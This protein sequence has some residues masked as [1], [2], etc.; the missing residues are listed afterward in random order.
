MNIK[1]EISNNQIQ[2]LTKYNGF[3]RLNKPNNNGIY[4]LIYLDPETVKLLS[5]SASINVYNFDDKMYIGVKNYTKEF[6]ITNKL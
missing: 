4:E 6:L 3:I 2:Y 1:L 5:A